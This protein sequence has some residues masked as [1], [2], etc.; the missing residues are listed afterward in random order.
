MGIRPKNGEFTKMVEQ[1]DGF[2]LELNP[3]E[4]T[5]TNHIRATHIWEPISTEIVRQHLKL[6]DTF[7]DVGAHVG[8]Y[9]CL[10]ASIVG[11]S[12][13][14]IAYEPHPVS[15]DYLLKNIELNKFKNV[16]AYSDALWSFHSTQKFKFPIGG[17]IAG[18]SKAQDGDNLV[19]CYTLDELFA[20]NSVDFIKIDCQGSDYFILEG[21]R[22]LLS[23]S[24]NIK[25]LVEKEGGLFRGY[26]DLDFD[27]RLKTL[28]LKVVKHIQSEQQ[29]FCTR[30][31]L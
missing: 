19:R 16:V 11:D 20:P 23:E 2:K 31:W 7:V 30:W 18:D 8:Y 28:G 5:V 14:V 9:T 10:A 29:L 24:L 13:K 22:K 26:T 6:G 25:V 12:G 17:N 3:N 27:N 1:L 4:D 21:G 15:Y